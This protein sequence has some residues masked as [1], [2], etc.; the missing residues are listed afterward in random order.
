MVVV[1]ALKLA[2]AIL[3]T[4]KNVVVNNMKVV[5]VSL[6]LT[7]TYFIVVK[8]LMTGSFMWSLILLTTEPLTAMDDHIFVVV[9]NF[10]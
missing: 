3:V 4:T 5:V 8:K 1:N 9:S 7:T 6:S 10:L 2:T